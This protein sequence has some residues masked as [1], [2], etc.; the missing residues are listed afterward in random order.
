MTWYYASG[1][2]QLGPVDEAALDD[3]VNRGV[4]RDD[5]LVWKAGMANWQ[6]LQN[7]RPRPM[8]VPVAQ[9]A[10]PAGMP[11]GG[12]GPAQAA[13]APAG[14]TRFCSECGRPFPMNQLYA[15]GNAT[16]CSS[17]YPGYMQRAGVG[18]M[19]QPY[20]QPQTAGGVH[21]GGFWIRFV[22][23]LIDGILVGI[24]STIIRIPLFLLMGGGAVL[25]M[26]RNSDPAAAMAALPMIMGAAGLSFL[27]QIAL[28]V[29]YE[30]YFLS[31]RGATLGKIA[32]GLK[33]VRVDGAPISLGFGAGRF[34]AQMLSGMILAIGYIIAAFDPEKRSLHDRICNTRV[35]YSR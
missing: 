1:G 24:V 33:V 13:P 6:P 23:R 10:A 32:L 35:I 8:P 7:A 9:N 25:S 15:L 21:Y 3:L 12:S 30:A 18:G 29:A 27:I 16:V 26:G 11:Q 28:S 17:C 22:A 19:Q 34:F 5:T 14:D 2:Q 20:M 31:T 4:V